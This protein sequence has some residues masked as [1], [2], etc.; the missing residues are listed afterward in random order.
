L[1]LPRRR[2]SAVE[3]RRIVEETFEPGSSVARVARKYG[4]NANQV[5]S[6][7]H[8]VPQGQTRRHADDA[9][10]VVAG[11]SGRAS[12]SSS[13]GRGAGGP[14]SGG[15]DPDQACWPMS[16]AEQNQ[17]QASGAEQK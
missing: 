15:H 4:V 9:G 13:R 16:R 8:L 6:V 10:E 2:R 5:F 3:R 7:A 11:V 14:G 17:S 12:G 1:Q